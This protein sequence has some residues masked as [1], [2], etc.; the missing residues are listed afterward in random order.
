MRER[1]DGICFTA[2]GRHETVM[3]KKLKQCIVLYESRRSMTFYFI[4]CL[5][6]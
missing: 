2:L 4:K 3:K 1:L 6:S 5:Q